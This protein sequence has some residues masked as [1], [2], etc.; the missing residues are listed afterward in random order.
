M[1]NFEVSVSGLGVLGYVEARSRHD[2]TKKAADLWPEF[3]PSS[4]TVAVA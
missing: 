3:R 2:A 4:F 1:R